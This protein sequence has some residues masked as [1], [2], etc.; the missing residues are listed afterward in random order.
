M[1]TWRLFAFFDC[2]VHWTGYVSNGLMT[3]VSYYSLS[4]YICTRLGSDHTP[5]RHCQSFQS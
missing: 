1:G 3:R 5:F 2:Y 4:L